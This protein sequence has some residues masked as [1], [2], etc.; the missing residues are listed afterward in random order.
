MP[1]D[2]DS[3]PRATARPEAVREEIRELRQ[4]TERPFGLNLFAPGPALADSSA[5][6]AYAATLAGE[7]ERYGVELGEPV[8]DDDRWDEKLALVADEGI[9]VVSVTFG[10][11][12]R[13]EVDSPAGR[14]M[15]CVGDRDHRRRGGQRRGGGRR[16]ARGAGRGGR[17]AIA[18]PS[19]SVLPAT[20]AFSLYSSS[21][22]P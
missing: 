8:H 5:L 20:S 6:G 4:L 12:S 21:W 18:A 19:T 16:R 11:P 2:W 1:A 10:C 14:R 22:A 15:R 13:S 7:A 9:A 17:A 3:S